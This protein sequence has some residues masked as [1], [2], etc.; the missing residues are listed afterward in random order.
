M[1][2]KCG[3]CEAPGH[4]AWECPVKE[5]IG[6]DLR[7]RLEAAELKVARLGQCPHGHTNRH[8]FRLYDGREAVCDWVDCAKTPELEDL[9]ARLEAAEKALAEE[10]NK[11]K[12][13]TELHGRLLD[14]TIDILDT[15]L[16]R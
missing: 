5:S 1:S 8:A 2:V 11:V 6:S 12:A 13:L 9:R 7:S 3:R 15:K 16:S 4:F 10:R 14:N